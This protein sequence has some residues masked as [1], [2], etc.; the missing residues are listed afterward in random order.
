MR[1]PG[2]ALHT[3]VGWRHRIL[4]YIKKSDRINSGGGVGFSVLLA[5]VLLLP[6][7]ES[8]ADFLVPQIT[9]QGGQG[10]YGASMATLA[11]GNFLV[12]WDT[13]ASGAGVA[14]R[15]FDSKGR[16]LGDESML[17]PDGGW[18]SVAARA[19]GSFVVAM[20]VGDADGIGIGAGVVGFDLNVNVSVDVNVEVAANDWN[21]VVAAADDGSFLIVWDRLGVKFARMFAADGVP[22]S[23]ELD[24]FPDINGDWSDLAYLGG[25]FL[26]VVQD[27]ATGGLVGRLIDAGGGFAG[28]II[29]LSTDIPA[30]FNIS[31]DPALKRTPSGGFLLAWDSVTDYPH[32]RR[33]ERRIF[34]R[35]YLADGTP[36]GETVAVSEEGQSCDTP[37]ITADASGNYL[38]VFECSKD[39][40]GGRFGKSRVAKARRFDAADNPLGEVFQVNVFGPGDQAFVAAETNPDGDSLVTW[41]GN[42]TPAFNFFAFSSRPDYCGT[43]GSGPG[44]FDCGRHL[45]GRALATRAVGCGA[46]ARSGCLATLERSR[47]KINDGAG[48]DSRASFS[49][50][51]GWEGEGDYGEPSQVTDYSVCVYGDEAGTPA[52]QLEVNVPAGDDCNA[53]QGCWKASRRAGLLIASSFRQGYKDGAAKHDGMNKIKLGVSG[54]GG[55]KV[56]LRGVGAGLGVPDL[57]GLAAPVTVQLANSNEECWEATYESGLR[58]SADSFSAVVR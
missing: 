4:T 30:H 58:Q 53:G 44:P 51:A 20:M 47:L 8:R 43:A 6:A 55:N 52:L 12:A 13:A 25:N 36:A 11:D 50:S 9:D 33:N 49:W 10:G 42:L 21:P 45:F 7:L 38:V 31:R 15:K 39:R 14:V 3:S 5:A 48:Q 28:G 32:Q 35:R 22:L 23:G 27:D 24:V 41:V 29:P 19:D 16:A 34:S 56:K 17:F 26:V 2:S 1:Y 46:Q 37:S 18:P 40:D 57:A 54:S